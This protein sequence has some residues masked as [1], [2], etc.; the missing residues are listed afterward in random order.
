MTD[1]KTEAQRFWEA[2]TLDP[3]LADD[4]YKLGVSLV[5]STTPLDDADAFLFQHGYLTDTATLIEVYEELLD[6]SLIPWF[7]VYSLYTADDDERHVLEVRK[8]GVWFDAAPI[9]RY[10]IKDA[11][12]GWDTTGTAPANESKGELTFRNVGLE[13]T[14]PAV[15]FGPICEG[16]FTPTAG[17]ELK[18]LKGKRGVYGKA[19]VTGDDEAVDSLAFWAGHYGVRRVSAEGATVEFVPPDLVLDPSGS[20]DYDGPVSASFAN[21]IL[22]WE[23]GANSANTS[24]GR[25]KFALDAYGNKTFRGAIVADAQ[26]GT[27]TDIPINAI[28]GRYEDFPQSSDLEILTAVCQAGV[29]GSTYTQTLVASGGTAPYTWQT[30]SQLPK[31]LALSKDAI[32]GTPTEDGAFSLTIQVDDAK[33]A[34]AKRSMGLSI[35]ANRSPVNVASV[36]MNVV[37]VATA[38]ASAMLFHKLKRRQQKKDAQSKAEAAADARRSDARRNDDP[39]NIALDDMTQSANAQSSLHEVARQADERSKAAAKEVSRQERRRRKA[40]ANKD[41]AEAAQKNHEAARDAATDETTRDAEQ[42][43][44]DAEAEKANEAEQQM[45]DAGRAR[46]AE[47]EESRSNEEAADSAH[48]VEVV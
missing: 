29:I 18:G 30:Q 48:A 4:F 11:T 46:D 35:A 22:S 42:A 40:K 34:T 9:H 36:S 2:I 15:Y 7:G 14:D 10:T 6:T 23:S 31:G 38:F 26:A 5:P 28:G 27:A 13:A 44:A 24:K 33:G 21:N 47:S 1:K 32:T 12:L 39:D 20:V 41:A 3:I 25:I 37:A 17:K 45:E 19:A 16:T 43:K 8:A